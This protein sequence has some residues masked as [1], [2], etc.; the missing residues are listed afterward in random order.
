MEASEGTQGGRHRQGARATMFRAWSW[1]APLIVFSFA[2]A[3]LAQSGADNRSA[4]RDEMIRVVEFETF[5]LSGET[6]IREIDPDVLEAMREVPRHLF[7]PEPLRAYAY[8]NHPL[9]VG[10]EQNIAAPLLVALM[11]HLIEPEADDVV[12]ETGTG[13]GYHAA[14]LSR[15]AGRV[16]SVEVVEPLA[17]EAGRR[18]KEQ[19]YDN[20]FT[21]A[22]DGYYGWPEHAPYDAMVIKEALDHVP[23]TLLA[24]LKRGGR[25]VLPLGPG[26]GPQE[27]TVITKTGNG[28][29]S[30]RR[31]MPVRFSPLQ[32]GERL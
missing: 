1:L 32:G 18:L 6:G 13:A 19:G 5:F 7:V 8:G 31:I 25:M 4:E 14:V 21:R 23:P 17:E 29:F 24:Q 12:F 3:A 2:T 28:K 27:L 16:Y 15:L 20:V 10:Y 9:P 11:T 26:G 30:E 22:G